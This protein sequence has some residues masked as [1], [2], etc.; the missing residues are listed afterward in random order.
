M[1]AEVSRILGESKSRRGTAQ[2]DVINLGPERWGVHLVTNVDGTAG[3]RSFEADSCVALATATALIVALAVD[4]VRASAARAPVESPRAEA[5][6]SRP[7][8]P[9]HALSGLVAMSVQGDLGSLPSVA[10]SGELAAGVTERWIRVEAL[11]SLWALQDANR[12]ASEGA[13]LQRIEAGLRG[14]WRGI[15]RGSVEADPCLGARL[16]HL[17]SQGF[18]ET[19]AYQRDAWGWSLDGDVLATWTLIGPLA[20][21]GMLGIALPLTRPPV[22]L[23]DSQGRTIQIQQSSA[24]AGRAALGLEVRF[25]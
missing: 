9:G 5:P 17:S 11:G 2:A 24:V 25:P 23:V 18:G 4:P 15:A 1:L 19:T 21:R 3:E 10:A 8:P 6:I 7:D 12:S 20:L 22:V 16:T 13:H 14:C